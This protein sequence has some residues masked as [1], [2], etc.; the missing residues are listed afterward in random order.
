MSANLKSY[1]PANH[2]LFGGI[3][4]IATIAEEI[5]LT[6]D[7]PYSLGASVFGNRE[8]AK[9]VARQLDVGMVGINKVVL[10]QLGRLGWAPSKVVMDIAGGLLGI[11]N[12]PR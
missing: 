12:L 1:N 2:E 10:G 4:L 8:E 6:N 3:R 5:T 9:E 11:V 7:N